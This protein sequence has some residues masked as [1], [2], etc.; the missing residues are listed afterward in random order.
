MACMGALAA[1]LDLQRLF[2]SSALP[3]LLGSSMISSSKL[4]SIQPSKT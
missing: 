2:D 1:A 3:L 4:L